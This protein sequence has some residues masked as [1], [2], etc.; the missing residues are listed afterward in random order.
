MS[1]ELT[2]DQI[3]LLCDIEESDRLD[4]TEEK[5][6]YLDV[7]ISQGYVEAGKGHPAS[8]LQLTV[9]GMEFLGQR[10]VG[11]NEA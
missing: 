2:D 1:D 8:G 10:G 3:S 6:R 5:K 11:L 7:L 9:K 4:L